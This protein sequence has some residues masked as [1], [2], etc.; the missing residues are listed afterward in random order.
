MSGAR[1]KAL[2]VEADPA[3]A[4]MIGRM[5]AEAKSVQF[6]LRRAE[7]LADGLAMLRDDHFDAVV[8]DLSL[9]DA[10][11]LTTLGRVRTQAPT[12]PIVVISGPDDQALAVRAVGSGA[13]DYLPR[14][15]ISGDL[16][17]RAIRYAIERQRLE[18]AL[19]QAEEWE[20]QSWTRIQAARDFRYYSA[21]SKDGGPTAGGEEGPAVPAELAAEYRDL[22]IA[23]VQSDRAIE[24]RP[25]KRLRELAR[26]LARAGVAARDVMRFHLDVLA[27]L[28]RL[29]GP[30]ELPEVLTDVR[31][32]ILDLMGSLVDAY[33][34]GRRPGGEGPEPGR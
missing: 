29:A 14:G 17:A 24:V 3:D 18:N 4:Q 15:R 6:D 34:E 33:R 9:P 26:R 19:E 10:Q 13:Q 16:L 1:I 32:V 23:Y 25:V 20:R 31:L 11:G 21:V 2:L 5:L 8:L 28:E 7:R 12:V 30:E 27:K 22:V